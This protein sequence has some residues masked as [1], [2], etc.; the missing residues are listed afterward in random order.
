[1]LSTKSILFSSLITGALFLWPLSASALSY[2]FDS[3]LGNIGNTH[4][5]SVA[6]APNITASGFLNDGHTADLFG[7]NDSPS[8]SGLGI[9]NENDHEIDNLHFVQLDLSGLWAI[10]PSGLTMTIGSAQSGEGFNLFGS[11]SLSSL[12]T[13][14]S[15]YT[16]STSGDVT[17]VT[18]GS[19]P[20]N[21]KYLGVQATNGDVLIDT[22]AVNVPEPM[23][24]LILGAALGLV[25]LAKRRRTARQIG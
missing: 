8:E 19:L 25:F 15:G 3:P 23:T 16:T 4:I 21:F 1:M 18:F 22:L 6:G 20:N 5:Y 12:G 13:Q 14:L 9:N 2:S 17:T 11:N 24:Y 7:K 10:S